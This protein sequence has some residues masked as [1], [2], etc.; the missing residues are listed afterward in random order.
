MVPHPDPGGSLRTRWGALSFLASLGLVGLLGYDATSQPGLLSGGRLL[1][2]AALSAGALIAAWAVRFGTSGR[3]LRRALLLTLAACLALSASGAWRARRLHE[4]PEHSHRLASA[5]LSRRA[6]LIQ[7]EFASLLATMDE[8]LRAALPGARGLVGEESAFRLLDSASRSTRFLG[9]KDG[10]GLAIYGPR[11]NP[12]AWAGASYPLPP[13]LLQTFGE[14]DKDVIYRASAERHLTRIYALRRAGAHVLVSEVTIDSSLDPHLRDEALPELRGDDAAIVRLHDYRRDLDGFDG[15]FAR[16]GDRYEG[17]AE[18]DRSILYVGLRAPDTSFL[19]HVQLT[20]IATADMLLAV[21]Q[22]H[23]LVA[24][25]ALLGWACGLT[26]I[27]RFSRFAAQPAFAFAGLRLAGALAAVW[28]IRLL[29]AWLPLS[30]QVSGI[31]LFGPRLFASARLYPLLRSP[32]DLLL[33][34][35]ALLGTGLLVHQ[36][37]AGTLRPGSRAQRVL[38]A[39]LLVLLVAVSARGL[40]ALASDMVANSSVNLL[41]VDLSSPATGALV[42]QAS[43]L[44]ILTAMLQIAQGLM[45]WV[46]GSTRWSWLR[47]MSLHGDDGLSRWVLASFLPGMLLACLLYQPLFAPASERATE[48]LFEDQLWPEVAGQSEARLALIQATMDSLQEMPGLGD[49]LDT[50]EGERTSLALDLWQ[51]TPLSGSGYSASLRVDDPEGRIVSRFAWN[52]PPAFDLRA[53]EDPRAQ[54]G[55]PQLET[56][57]FQDVRKNILHAHQTVLSHGRVAGSVT[58]HV[59]EE[60]DNLPFLTPET[61][62]VRALAPRARRI[63]TLPGSRRILHAVYQPDGQTVFANQRQAPRLTPELSHLIT[64][65][66]RSVWIS[67]REEGAPARY[68]FFGDGRHLFALGYSRATPLE[69]VARAL[70]T[71]LF[72]LLLAGLVIAPVLLSPLSGRW[73]GLSRRVMQTLG[74][75]QYRKLLTTFAFTTALPL[76]ALA[77]LMQE[78]IVREM[79]QEIEERGWQAVRSAASLVRT[80]LVTDEQS[81]LEDDLLYWIGQQVGH[82]VNLYERGEVTATSRRELFSSGLVSPRVDGDVYR[83]I[84]IEGRRVAMSNQTMRE[85]PYRMITAPLAAGRARAA[86]LLSLPLDAQTAEAERRAREVGDVVLITSVSMVLLLGVVGYA[87]ARRISRPIRDLKSAAAQIAA[88]DLDAVVASRASDET[89]DLILTFNRMAQA[90]KEQ[91]EDLERRRDYIEKILQNATIGVVSMDQAGIVVTRNPAALTLLEDPSL[92]PGTDFMDLVS[93]RPELAPLSRLLRPPEGRD[94]SVPEGGEAE[95]RLP[96]T[97]EQEKNVRARAV[98][99]LEGRGV[100]LL[101]EDVTETVRSN[102]LAAWAEMARRIAHE[103]KNP[104]TPIQLSAEHIRR[105]HAERHPDFP[106]VLDECLRTIMEEVATLREISAEFSTYARIPTPR[107]ERVRVHDLLAEI[108]RPYQRALPPG[109]RLEMD[110]PPDLPPIEADRSLLTRAIVNL[111]ENALQAMPKGGRLSVR[112]SAT[113]R[114]M[115]IEVADTGLGMDA[116]AQARI[117]EPYFSTKDTGTGL[118]LAIARKAVEEHGG[119]IEVISAL[120]RGTTMTIYLPLPRDVGRTPASPAAGRR[121]D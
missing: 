56:S 107:K 90:L 42:L 108:L 109:M 21:E 93:R 8:P 91:R 38:G 101:L 25:V 73:S 52:L 100:I 115:A 30:F 105:V 9:W 47:A 121:A 62:Y 31:D 5:D 3:P 86:A 13:G 82:D 70:R 63:A 88:G 102:R 40:P 112:A 29:I 99:F 96:G 97:P 85:L 64:T 77:F 65:P 104:L 75:T 12:M 74:R 94:G 49:A 34:A 120:Q 116:A 37:T 4:L 89:G 114:E 98:P 28:I 80:V 36:T 51:R 59:L 71:M 15:I 24:A 53:Q 17:A 41:V 43:A 27:L 106:R 117:F 11:G 10:R 20:G 66:G 1:L 50:D 111:V 57:A 14:K 16:R 32:G 118:G 48:A 58:V 72:G 55:E 67:A 95:L 69:H 33:T 23:R 46:I 92:S 103:I 60:F 39:M 87:L 84:V 61:P 45:G 7:E 19:G 18:K 2:L 68:L 44:M 35:L 6:N 81:Q 26:V 83:R 22:Q 54:E 79:D 78:Y 76:M 119:R 113:E 110:A